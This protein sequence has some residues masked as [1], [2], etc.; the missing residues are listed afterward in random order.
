[1]PDLSSLIIPL[2]VLLLS[3]T[4]HEAAHALSADM[5]G[6][7][8]ARRLGR[9]SLN[10]VVHIDPIGTLLF[11]ALALFS[12]FPLIGWAKPVPVTPANLHPH[13]ARKYMLIAAA[14][15]ASNLVLAVIG[16]IGVQMIGFGG[17]SSPATFQIFNFFRIMV[18]L[19]VLLAVFNMIP[20]PPLDGGNVLA[21]L[22]GGR[23]AQVLDRIRPY[24]IFILYGLLLSGILWQIVDPIQFAILQMLGL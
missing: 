2:V 13:W 5:L 20:V 16:A 22:V 8:T 11:P 14:G 19:N 4:V 9:V 23:G 12:G 6:D 7:P 3:L 18:V 17:G 10:P 24:G 21:G 15:P 1:V